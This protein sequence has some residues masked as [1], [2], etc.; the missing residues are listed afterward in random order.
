V[1]YLT[2]ALIS[3]ATAVQRRLRTAY[4]WH[5]AVWQ[6]FPNRENRDSLTR[7]DVRPDG[8]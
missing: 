4:S 1:I 2:H 6:A 5:Q 8:Y 7:L 3:H